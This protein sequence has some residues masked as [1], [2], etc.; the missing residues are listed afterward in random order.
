[1]LIKTIDII[2]EIKEID[3]KRDIIC[4]FPKKQ[5]VVD[6]REDGLITIYSER[7]INFS[8]NKV[9]NEKVLIDYPT[10][11][12]ISVPLGIHTEFIPSETTQYF[13]K[14]NIR[15]VP[16]YTMSDDN[17]AESIKYL[18]ITFDI[19]IDLD[20]ARHYKSYIIPENRELLYIKLSKLWCSKITPR[21]FIV[22]DNNVW[23]SFIDCF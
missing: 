11:L 4:C 1:M 23:N 21:I 8:E 9:K 15:N 12:S 22:K 2:D 13:D 5:N 7:T 16:Y 20:L 17:E 6:V 14:I 10:S 3:P 18:N 19:W